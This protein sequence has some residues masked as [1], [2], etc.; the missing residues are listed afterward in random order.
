MYRAA[1]YWRNRE[2]SASLLHHKWAVGELSVTLGYINNY[3]N[4]WTIRVFLHNTKPLS[5]WLV[6]YLASLLCSKD[7]T[8]LTCIGLHWHAHKFK[9]IKH[10]QHVCV[11]LMYNKN[12]ISRYASVRERVMFIRCSRIFWIILTEKQ[13][14]KKI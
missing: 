5:T 4:V 11:C 1:I 14:E 3:S 8:P 2:L 13:L 7:L 9:H 6:P 10:P 12:W